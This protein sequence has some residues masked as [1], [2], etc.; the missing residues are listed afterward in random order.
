MD[1]QKVDFQTHKYYIKF[2]Y[3]LGEKQPPTL[4]RKKKKGKT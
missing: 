1:I 4:K 2:T 3:T